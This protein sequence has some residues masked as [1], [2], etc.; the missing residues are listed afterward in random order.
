MVMRLFVRTPSSNHF[1][2]KGKRGNEKKKN[3]YSGVGVYSSSVD[4]HNTPKLLD[5]LVYFFIIKCRLRDDACA[6][7]RVR[8][9]VSV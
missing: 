8:V 1:L 9:H 5:S 3:K 2:K 4:H 7:V 6:A